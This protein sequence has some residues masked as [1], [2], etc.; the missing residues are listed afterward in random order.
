M[1][2]LPSPDIRLVV[3]DMDGTLLD[4]DKRVPADFWPVLDL[5]HR[6]GIVFAP[7][8]GRQ[9]ATLAR[10][11][12]GNLNGM[13][14]IAENGAYVVRDGHEFAS[15][16]LDRQVAMAM[17][18]AARR[19]AAD[20][21]DIGTVLC[22]KRSAYVERT[23][24]AFLAH[25][26]P[27]YAALERVGDLTVVDD[28]VLK[29]AVFDFGDVTEVV[30]PALE[31]VLPTPNGTEPS[32]AQVVVSGEHWTDVMAPRVTKGDAV[33]RLQAE[34]GFGPD[35]T[36]AF[37]DYLNDLTMLD[38]A[39]WSFAVAGAHPQVRARARYLAPSNT[40]HGVVRVLRQMLAGSDR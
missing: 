36:V 37:G 11:F 19:V 32:P 26:E 30:A 28:D 27:Y 20:G 10:T 1:T 21:R 39:T 3:T 18:E 6:R 22:G 14:V 38:A 40:E 17:V 33:G 8:S 31:A 35:Q 25:S 2:E 23:D 34:L 15:T 24:A 4:G 29:V 5:M 12:A 7:A 13:T 16:S 9:Y